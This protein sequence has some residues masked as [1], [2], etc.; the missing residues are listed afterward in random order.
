M[1]KKNKI[2]ICGRKCS[3]LYIL[4][5]TIGTRIFVRICPKCYYHF[6][7]IKNRKKFKSNKTNTK[8][9]KI[10]NCQYIKCNKKALKKCSRCK[11]SRY[12]SRKCQKKDWN[13]KH[14]FICVKC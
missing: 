7:R 4:E 8:Q 5:K 9:K 3:K 6:R 14:R 13:T 12:C 11:S 2:C 10:K 1:G